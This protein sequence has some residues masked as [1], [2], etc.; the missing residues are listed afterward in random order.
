MPV[1]RPGSPRAEIRGSNRTSLADLIGA[2]VRDLRI[3]QDDVRELLTVQLPE[4]SGLILPARGLSEG[5]VRFL[6]LCVLLEDPS[7]TGLI[8]LERPENGIHRRTW[9]PWFT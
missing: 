3:D 9:R 5:T 7:V 8:C 4:P 1:W 6:A 2:K